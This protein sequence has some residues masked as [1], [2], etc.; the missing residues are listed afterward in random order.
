MEV[1]VSG[2]HRALRLTF[3]GQLDEAAPAIASAAV[4]VARADRLALHVDTRPVA[5]SSEPILTGVRQLLESARNE[6]PVV[7][8]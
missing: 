3:V 1:L 2:T 8:R 6:L 7:V 5:P 4:V